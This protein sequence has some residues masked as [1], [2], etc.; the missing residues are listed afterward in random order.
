MRMLRVVAPVGVNPPL[1]SHQRSGPGLSAGSGG[2]AAAS[3]GSAGAGRAGEG[4]GRRGEGN[5]RRDHQNG[6]STFLI[7]RSTFLITVSD[8][9]MTWNCKHLANATLRHRIDAA[10]R[11]AGYEPP[12]I[13]TPLELLGET[14]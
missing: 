5:G 4:N 14:A 10:C 11:N 9:L 2:G 6:R 3:A 1:R 12:A 13:C 7:T 8:H